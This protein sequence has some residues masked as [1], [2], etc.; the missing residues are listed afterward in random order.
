MKFLTYVSNK[1]ELEIIEKNRILEIIVN[2]L[3]F[4][5]SKDIKNIKKWFLLTLMPFNNEIDSIKKILYKLVEYNFYG[6]VIQDLSILNIIK[7]ENINLKIIIDNS[8]GGNNIEFYRFFENFN[9]VEAVFLSRELPVTHILEYPKLKINFISQIHGLL[10]IFH[11]KRKLI[12]A[13]KDD[14]DVNISKTVFLQ[15]PKRK[16]EY[17]KLEENAEGTFM[18][19]SKVISLQNHLKELEDRE[20]IG[21]I[22]LRHHKDIKV[23]EQ[24]LKFYINNDKTTSLEELERLPLFES[25]RESILNPIKTVFSKNEEKIE[26]KT[27]GKVID[28]S[29]SKYIVLKSSVN[30][31]KDMEILFINDKKKEIIYKISNFEKFSDEIYVIPWRKGVVSNSDF[32]LS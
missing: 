11:T 23:Y 30:L 1:L 12:T 27:I 26:R 7:D 16:D 15:E 22:D 10:K 21:M 2:D 24:I 5:F 3:N 20:I 6:V 28:S 9:M 8:T 13:I 25:G 32:F 14:K 31:E 4:S 17:F 29:K 19:H 18:Y